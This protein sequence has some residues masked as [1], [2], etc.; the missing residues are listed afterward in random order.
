MPLHED[1]RKYTMF[2]TEEGRFQYRVIPRGFS[3]SGDAY[4]QRFDRLIE[5][6]ERKTKKCR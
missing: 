6:V 5:D 4:N 3:G 1:D 2:V